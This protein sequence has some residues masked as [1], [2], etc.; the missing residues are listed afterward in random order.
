MR[1][2]VVIIHRS[3]ERI[4]H[5]LKF[6]R[7]I[8]DDSFF[9]VECVL[10]KFLE[11][12]LRDQFLGPDIDFEFDVVLGGLIH[13]HWFLEVVPQ[14]FAGGRGRF[15]GSIEIMP[16]ERL[17]RTKRTK[18]TRK[19]VFNGEARMTNDEVRMTKSFS[20]VKKL[21]P[22]LS[23]WERRTRSASE[24]SGGASSASAS[25]AQSSALHC[26]ASKKTGGEMNSPPGLKFGFWFR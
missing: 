22:F 8:A 9:A 7:L 17:A 25:A 4:D 12:R 14:H 20:A 3:I 19:T 26:D 13:L 15:N 2:S 21:S 11:Q 16:H 24:G 5:P 6:A 23:Q 1:N 18:C 10:R